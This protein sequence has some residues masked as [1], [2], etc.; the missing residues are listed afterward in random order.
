MRRF[1]SLFGLVGLI[2]VLFGGIALYFTGDP[3]LYVL[4][5]LGLGV[6]LLLWFVATRFRELGSLLGARSTK[7]GANMVASSLLFVALLSG[8]NWLGSRYNR[9]WDLSESGAF[10]LSPQARS[11]LDATSGEVEMQAFLEGGQNPAIESVLDSFASASRNVKVRLV[12]PDKEPEFAE[13]HG[14]RSYGTVRL[15]HHVGDCT[16]GG[17]TDEDKSKACTATTVAQPTEESIT[18]A[19]IKVTR[20]E[21]QVLCF[22][23]GGG[24]PSPDDVEDP[25][26]YGVAKMALAA[27]NVETKKVFLSRDGRVPDDC[28][29]LALVGPSKPLTPE[30]VKAIGDDLAG[31]GRLLAMLS[32]GTGEALEPVLAE[33]GVGLG[34]DVVIDQVVDLFRGAQK[35]MDQYVST[36]GDHPITKDLKDRTIFRFTRSVTPEQGKPG[37]TAVAIATSSPTSWAESDLPRLFQQSLAELDPDTDRKGPIPIGVA[38]EANLKDLGKGDGTARLVVYG[39]SKLADNRAINQFFNRDLFLNSVA[40]LGSQEELVSIRPRTV[41]AS[42]VSFD[43]AQAARIFYLSVLILPELLLVAGLAVWWR[44][45]NL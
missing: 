13:R 31:G 35:V 7:Y 45:S 37:V 26:G 2:L 42:R 3:S 44:R 24:E 19:V 33:Y 25:G 29:V 14:V 36:Y 23:E 6:V 41:R 27:E 12:D 43:A 21:K 30:E 20:S 28:D 8:L 16:D 10:S 39:T 22:V 9:R 17:A 11:V 5:H 38:A 15:V 34:R 1:R 18:N 32:P 40:W 4:V